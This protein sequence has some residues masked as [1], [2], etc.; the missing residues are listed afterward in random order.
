MRES[1]AGADASLHAGQARMDAVF[2]VRHMKDLT[3]MRRLV[4]RIWRLMDP[5]ESLSTV[6]KHLVES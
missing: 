5:T 3:H 6:L 1:M 4:V 2:P